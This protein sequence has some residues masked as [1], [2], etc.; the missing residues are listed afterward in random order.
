MIGDDLRV[1]HIVGARPNF[2]KVAPVMNALRAREH[3]VQTLV[4]TGQH[5]DANMSDIF[6]EQLGIPAPD[7]NLA[8]GSGT[9]ARQ[10]ADIMTR[11]EPVLLDVQPDI[12]LVY[13]DVNSTVAAAL[14]CA[15]LAVRVG[16]VEAGLRSF[17]RTMP[18][19]IN[20]VVTDRLA[21]LLF[22]PSEDGDI[23]LQRE[24][25][26]DERIFRVGNVM[27]DTLVRLMPLAESHAEARNRSRFPKRYALVTL[28][29]PANV[30]DGAVL[31]RIL[32]SLLEVR[33][34][35]AVVFPAHPRTRKRIADFGLNTERLQ[36]LDPLPYVEFLGLQS[37]ATV[38]I[39]DSGGIQEET[40]YLGVPCLTVRENTERPVTVTYGTNVLVGRDPLKLRLEV[41]R[42]LAGEAKKG[43]VP[44]LWD[45]SAGKR[46]ADVLTGLER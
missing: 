45:G 19:E 39:T 43:K 8:V 25:I 35:L 21:D 11:F 10:T 24:G 9:H 5:Y 42:V 31:K 32:Q 27:I 4:H 29:R 13:G 41:A 23:N 40:T 6:F 38:V 36:V 12:V 34:E 26:S 7:V 37:R 22:T 18:E 3:V 30:D 2:M 33:E 14:V 46:I 17:D 28:H 20:R 44:P 1:L 15:K 16:H